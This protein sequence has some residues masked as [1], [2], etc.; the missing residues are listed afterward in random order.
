MKVTFNQLKAMIDD[1]NECMKV[2]MRWFQK[3]LNT[4]KHIKIICSM[5]KSGSNENNS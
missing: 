2:S 3:H 4:L 5:R 1:V